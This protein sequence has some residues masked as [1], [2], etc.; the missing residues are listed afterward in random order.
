AHKSRFS[1]RN[2]DESDRTAVP[3]N[4]VNAARVDLGARVDEVRIRST[5]VEGVVPE[6]HEHRTA[7]VRVDVTEVPG[8]QDGQYQLVHVLGLSLGRSVRAPLGKQV[9]ADAI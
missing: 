1:L 7:S 9:I 5:L 3:G 2:I 6:R 8:R 4:L